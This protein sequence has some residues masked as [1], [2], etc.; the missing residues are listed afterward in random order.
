MHTHLVIATDKI[1]DRFPERLGFQFGGVEL[2]LDL[3]K[4]G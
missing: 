1:V 2:L 3:E 4:C